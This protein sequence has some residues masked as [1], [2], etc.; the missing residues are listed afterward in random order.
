[1][2][3]APAATAGSICLDRARGTL[4]HMLM[5]DLSNGEIVLGKLA[6]RLIPVLTLVACALPMM[7][8]LTLVGGVDPSALIA[9]F[10]VSIG[11][12]VLGCSVA[13]VLSLWVGKTH[14]ALLGTYAFWGLWLLSRPMLA[15]AGSSLG[16][17]VPLP[18]RSCDPFWLSFAPYWSLGSV[19]WV[20]Y[21]WFVVV[22]WSLSALLV[23][24]A[25]LRIGSICTRD[26]V[27][28]VR[29]DLRALPFMGLL[30][31]MRYL[32]ESVLDAN[33]VLW[34]EWHRTRSSR[35][36]RLIIGVYVG[37]AATFTCF[38]ALPSSQGA[39]AAFVNGFQVSIGLLFLSVSAAT[40]LAEERARGSLD[41]V[42]ATPLPTWQIVLGKWLGAFRFVLLLTILP[43]ALGVG[44]V[45]K[46]YV[47]WPSV[48]LMVAYVICY[49]AAVVSFGLA[50]A[51]WVPTLGRSVGLTVTLYVICTVGLLFAALEL[52]GGGGRGIA[53]GSS[54]FGAG[55]MAIELKE[56][57]HSFHSMPWAILWTSFY[58]CAAV[59]LLVA[60]LASFNRCL[61]RASERRLAPPVFGRGMFG[62]GGKGAVGRDRSVPLP[63]V[64]T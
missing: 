38:A 37:L 34:R 44:I 7:E 42:M 29:F 1:M 35:W 9:A 63:T 54:F 52:H 17:A 22:T 59:G 3:V 51:T 31:R 12:A 24:L 49:G 60:T 8:L 47:R 4:M 32:P 10:A 48:V 16:L 5:T 41:V 27:R 6:A 46:D 53:M 20:G 19:T 57:G 64:E 11:V 23:G 62:Q 40:S 25:V 39:V 36:A 28:R 58:A 33:P 43:A 45:G 50:M 15:Q 18:P 55:E 26:A 30:D 2:L 61:G 56:T 21:A 14:E 13:L